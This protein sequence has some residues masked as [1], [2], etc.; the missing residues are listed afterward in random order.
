ME[1][2]CKITGKK[3]GGGAVVEI[4]C[5]LHTEEDAESE[6]CCELKGPSHHLLGLGSTR[7]EALME[8]MQMLRMIAE[9]VLQVR[10][11]FPEIP[12][13][14]WWTPEGEVVLDAVQQ[15]HGWDARWDAKAELATA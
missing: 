11:E 14:V 3:K 5:N 9:D 6:F 4:Y 10:G 1:H 12:G 15:Q 7:E 2:R 13:V 8:T